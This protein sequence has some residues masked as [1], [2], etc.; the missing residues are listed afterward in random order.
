MGKTFRPVFFK[1]TLARSLAS[2]G[3]ETEI[4]L[5]SFTTKD[6]H[7]LATSDVGDILF[8]IINPRGS[9]REVVSITAI[10]TSVTPPKG[11]GLVRGYAFYVATGAVTARLK[12]HS[13]GETVIITNDDHFLNT[14]YV[15]IDNAQT[16]SGLKTF[17]DA[18]RPKSATDTDAASDAEFVTKGQLGR[19]AI[20]GA[21]LTQVVIAGTAGETVALGNLLYFKESDQRWYKSDADAD[22]TANKVKLGIALGAGTAGVGITSGVVIKGYVSGLSGLTAG[23]KLYVSGTAGAIASTTPGAIQ[24]FI[25]WALS[26]TTLMFTPEELAENFFYGLAGEDIALG[27]SCYLKISDHKWYQTDSTDITKSLGVLIGLAQVAISSGASGLFRIYGIDTVQTVDQSAIGYSAFITTSGDSL[28]A[29]PG[30]YVRRVGVLLNTQ[31]FLMTANTD[32]P[33][34]KHL[35]GQEN[36]AVDAVG[37]DSYAITLPVTPISLKTGFEVNFKAATANT[38]SASLAV[39]GLTAKTI[40]RYINGTLSALVTGDIIAGQVV[41]VIY[42][43]TADAWIMLSLPANVGSALL[44]QSSV[45]VA[46]TNANTNKQA[47]ITQSILGGLLNT[48]NAIR[49]R[50]RGYWVGNAG[51]NSNNTLTVDYGATNVV[52]AV[53]TGTPSSATTWNFDWEVIIYATGATNSQSTRSKLQ[54]LGVNAAASADPVFI[55]STDGTCSTSAEDSTAA[56]NV[57]ISA[58][59]ASSGVNSM[60]INDYTIEVLR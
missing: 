57:V 42:E 60:T 10:D 25:G 5:N 46:Q 6:S 22:L 16:I 17:A 43:S 51:G 36:Y 15:D 28:F 8:L 12:A 3:S 53:I 21:N 11:T 13:P 50:M 49:I 48:G 24:R 35:W 27:D 40:K 59:L 38:G 33:Y 23:A 30:T 52:S 7:V 20:A 47:L 1:T 14:Q 18:A 58:Q 2:G 45:Q 44:F 37:T 56:K 9:N 4:Y 41:K 34:A 55:V 31:E 39:N 19:T 54:I 32:D 29:T 26:T